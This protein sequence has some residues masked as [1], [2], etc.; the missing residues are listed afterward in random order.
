[1]RTIAHA[2]L[3][4]FLLGSAKTAQAQ[5]AQAADK[6]RELFQYWCASCHGLAG[7]GNGPLAPTL[8][9]TVPDLTGI[10]ARN[11][12]VFPTI[13]VRRIIDGR[14]VQSHGDPDM[15]IWGTAFKSTKD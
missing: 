2:T 8:K 15:P 7:L 10:A 9:R 5:N 6:G 3:A 12:G 11:G 14:E 13:R 1:M 4:L